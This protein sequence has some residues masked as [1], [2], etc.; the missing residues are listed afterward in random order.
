MP[1]LE[2]RDMQLPAFFRNVRVLQVL[3]QIVF[4]LLLA[5]AAGFL[6]ANVTTNLAR[7]GLTVGYDFITNPASFDIGESYI[8]YQASDS[9]GRALLVG[10]V[11][12]LAVSALGIILTTIVG[13]I[14]GIARLSSNW[15]I[16]RLAA[17][18]VGVIRNTPLIIQLMFW[19]FGIIL[20][21]P[22]VKEAIAL[23]GS[24]YL[25]QRGLYLPWYEPMPTFESWRVFIWIALVSLA[26]IWF[27]FRWIQNRSELPLPLWSYPAYILV[28]IL[29]L[30][31][32]FNVQPEPPFIANFPELVGLNFRGGLRFTPE[33]AALLF[34]LVVYTGA[35]IAEIVRAG[36]QAVSRGQ[37]E[38]A[39]SLGLTSTQ[40]LRLII[41]P[42][43]LRVIIPPMTSQYLNLAK[44]SSLAIAIGY[45][46]LFSIAGT[47]INQTGATLEVIAIMMLSYLSMSLFTSLLM[48]MYNN[49]MRLVER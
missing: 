4:V 46:D 29:I 27:I 32:G 47:V 16:S 42:Q 30:W 3:A 12:T 40:S 26:V 6:Y 10:L 8:S 9:Y 11:N 2:L 39:R 37:V 20:Q 36:I 45:P 44:N 5:L 22:R 43:A 24:V 41:F 49:R 18:Y 14:A 15:L 7:Q 48:N 13:V 31:I 33:F 19:Y 38:A 23:P 17:S 28:P 1:P 35:F 34:G 25:T 21:L